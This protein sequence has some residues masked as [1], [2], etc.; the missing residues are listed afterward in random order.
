MERY[1]EN[2]TAPSLDWTLQHL[3]DLFDALVELPDPRHSTLLATWALG[4]YFHPLFL[5]FPR[6]VI[7]GESVSGKSKVL[8][9]LAETAWNAILFTSPTAATVFRLV[10]KYRATLLLDEVENL[11]NPRDPTARALVPL[12]NQGYKR[13]ARVPRTEGEGK[14]R[15]VVGYEVYSPM[16]IAGVT[17]VGAVTETRSI[18]LAIQRGTDLNRL[19]AQVDPHDPVFAEIRDACYRLCLVA[20]AVVAGTYRFGTLPA[21]L[22]GRA[23]EVW[24]PL[25]AIAAAADAFSLGT[26]F[27][28]TLLSLAEIDTKQRPTVSEEG[29]A[30]LLILAKML[31]NKPSVEVRPGE[32]GPEIKAAMGWEHS[33]SAER[34]SQQLRRFA[35]PPLGKDREGARY[36]V[37]KESLAK[38]ANAYGVILSDPVTAV[39][40]C[41]GRSGGTYSKSRVP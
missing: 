25:L 15:D 21:W 40:V 14:N 6:L 22:T 20:P 41:D 17:G 19:N 28:D 36:E 26:E 11:K 33:V 2:P 39:T 29:R 38:A 10:E 4:T 24:G 37:T 8:L 3:R 35:F 7:F 12:I 5:T 31:G 30:V 23:R 27:Q 16:A 9:V 32:L 34:A 13:G 18:T 1:L